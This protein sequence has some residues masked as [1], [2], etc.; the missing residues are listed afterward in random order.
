MSPSKFKKRSNSVVPVS[1]EIA[2]QKLNGF[3]LPPGVPQIARFSVQSVD[4]AK[5]PFS[6]LRFSF[7]YSVPLQVRRTNDTYQF[8]GEANLGW[9]AGGLYHYEG[10]ATGTNFFSTYR[11]KY[12]HGTF[13]MGRPSAP[14]QP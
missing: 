11:C 8:L 9:L 4:F 10:S 13:Q 12:D 5:R 2:A 14:R 6:V 3:D 7:G 1:G